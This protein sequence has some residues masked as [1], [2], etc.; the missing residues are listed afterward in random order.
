MRIEQR[1]RRPEYNKS[2]FNPVA[3]IDHFKFFKTLPKMKT[4]RTHCNEMMVTGVVGVA[5]ENTV[6]WAIEIL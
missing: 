3:S 5:V 2:K 6:P 1:L 4:K